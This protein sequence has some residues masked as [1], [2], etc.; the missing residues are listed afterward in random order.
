MSLKRTCR[1]SWKE[2]VITDDDLDFY[3]K[4]SP[5]IWGEK[6]N[7]PAPT[8]CPEERLRRR[9]SWRG[10]YHL[11][12]T[13]CAYSGKDIITFYPPNRPY[14]STDQTIW[15]SDSVE[16]LSCGREY[17]DSK[18]F[19]EQFDALLQSAYLPCL[20]N[21]YVTNVNS[22]YV[23]GTDHLN[24]SYLVFNAKN[25]DNCEYSESVYYSQDIFDSYFVR[26]SDDCYDSV[27]II[28]C[29]SSISLEES[30]DCRS[31]DFCYNMKW[32][33]NCLLSF[34]QTNQKFMIENIQ[35]SEST[36]FE[37][38]KK[39]QDS[40]GWYNY[41][42]LK[43]LFHALKDRE[44][45]EKIINYN[46]ENSTGNHLSNCS[47]VHF[48]TD[49]VESKNCKYVNTLWK[50]EDVYDSFSWGYSLE[51]AYEC[52]AV[53]T[54][55]SNIIGS[56]A[57]WTDTSFM[58]YSFSCFSCNHCFG[59]VG[60]KNKSYCILN[61]QYSK[62]AYEILVKKIIATM[63]ENAEWWE[64]LNVEIS[65]WWY[66]EAMA[67]LYFPMTREAALE[68][69]YQWNDYEPPR[70]EAVKY[71]SAIRLP[72]N[73][74]EIPDDIQNWAIECEI[75]GKYYKITRPE[76]EFYRKHHLPI[77]KKHY[78]IRRKERFERRFR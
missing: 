48:A 78:D 69:W 24:N 51:N 54:N 23:N 76:L 10:I 68:M 57:V 18:T 30:E 9:L 6:F 29:H 66:N 72:E 53:G 44:N 32:C 55:A 17:D 49:V 12:R 41:N 62:E 35:Y 14:K 58:Y 11:Y 43:K 19:T 74:D 20:S 2:F 64:Y 61:Q 13:K 60:L 22:D 45:I 15:W 56:Y 47:N 8:L 34:G 75:S 1:I 7:I 33:S 67:N 46:S 26:E 4:I 25:S 59:C 21:S 39:Y 70:P 28:R 71:V 50:A 40:F 16:N 63:R 73:I 31:V 38:K 27:G 77:P 3:E 5:V 52:V 37:E 65:P 36:Y 42:E